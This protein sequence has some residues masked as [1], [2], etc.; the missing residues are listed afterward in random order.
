MNLYT[1]TITEQNTG[2]INNLSLIIQNA[3]TRVIEQQSQL[4]VEQI[5]MRYFV[6]SFG[7]YSQ[8]S[9]LQKGIV[10]KP[11]VSTKVGV[12]GGVRLGE[13]KTAKFVSEEKVTITPRKA[14]ALAIPTTRA[15]YYLQKGVRSL[16]DIPTLERGPG[17]LFYKG[18][19][20]EG[21]PP[22][23]LRKSAV[24]IKPKISVEKVVEDFTV[25]V[26]TAIQNA[27]FNALKG[28]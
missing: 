18:Q 8:G 3:L 5:K 2:I 4:L 11:V 6:S 27:V 15:A 12:A 19:P 24:S 28:A 21:K 14:G 13:M 25:P 20:K 10:G 26:T 1:V 9:D 22:F 23:V 17:G 7:M 16:R